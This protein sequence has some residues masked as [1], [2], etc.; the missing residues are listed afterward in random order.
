MSVRLPEPLQRLTTDPDA[1]LHQGAYRSALRDERLAAIL[2]A[3][4]GI[5]FSICFITGLYSHLQQNPVSWL[6][7]QPRPAGLYRLS[8]GLHVVAGI[9]SIPVLIAKLWVVWPRFV[10]FP[11]ARRLS[12]L[13]ERIGLFP[14]VAGGIFMTFARVANIDPSYAWRVCFRAA[15]H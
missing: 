15:H 5:L 8:Q 7:I 11:V 3:S 10:S 12:G 1:P 9:A 2:G 14:L 6:P 13:V 4:L